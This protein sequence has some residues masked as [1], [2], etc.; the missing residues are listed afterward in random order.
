[1]YTNNSSQF[2]TDDEI[3]IILQKGLSKNLLYQIKFTFGQ[4]IWRKLFLLEYFFLEK[5]ANFH[6]KQ[7]WPFCFVDGFNNYKFG[8]GQHRDYKWFWRRFSVF[9]ISETLMGI[10][11]LHTILEV[12]FTRM[13][14]NKILF[15][16]YLSIRLKCDSLTD[17]GHQLMGKFHHNSTNIYLFFLLYLPCI[18]LHPMVFL[19]VPKIHIMLYDINIANFSKR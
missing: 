5:P 12:D 15:Q 1:M 9:N 13:Y 10:K 11:S 17:N 3:D 6:K 8:R 4:W 7:W 18:L 14:H 2:W 16:W 19:V